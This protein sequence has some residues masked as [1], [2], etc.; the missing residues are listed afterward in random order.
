MFISWSSTLIKLL[1]TSY[2]VCTEYSIVVSKDQEAIQMY[3]E[4][5]SVLPKGLYDK[6]TDLVI[7]LYFTP[8]YLIHSSDVQS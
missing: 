5:E 4:N 7:P 2:L 8:S 6:I 3:I 1:D